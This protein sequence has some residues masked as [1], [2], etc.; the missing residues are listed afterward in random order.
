M[1]ASRRVCVTRSVASATRS[2][3]TL[4]GIVS[5]KRRRR[6]YCSS[7]LRSVGEASAADAFTGDATRHRVGEASAKRRRRSVGEASAKRRRSVVDE[8]SDPPPLQTPGVA[9]T[10]STALHTVKSK[11][12]IDITRSPYY[13]CYVSKVRGIFVLS[14]GL[15][16]KIPRMSPFFCSVLIQ[17]LRRVKA[18]FN[19]ANLIMVRKLLGHSCFTIHP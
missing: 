7:R 18:S 9:F 10:R 19:F 15:F 4:L 2:A 8:A 14:R 13:G 11:H 12:N 5:A 17:T 1:L 16:E 6:R 3:A